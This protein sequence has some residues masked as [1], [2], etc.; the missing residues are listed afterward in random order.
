MSIFDNILNNNNNYIYRQ[1]GNP[2][3]LHDISY[4]V[5]KAGGPIN[6]PPDDFQK[7]ITFCTENGQRS[8]L[9]KNSE[10]N[11]IL[12]YFV[13]NFPISKKQFIL[14][15][16]FADYGYFSFVETWLEKNSD[17]KFSIGDKKLLNNIGY[18]DFKS[19]DIITQSL[20]ENYFNN[21]TFILQCFGDSTNLHNHDPNKISTNNF[22]VKQKTNPKKYIENSNVIINNICFKNY[23][24]ITN[25]SPMMIFR[26]ITLFE[27]F[28]FDFDSNYLIS[29]PNTEWTFEIAK[30]FKTKF[31]WCKYDFINY[32]NIKCE[33]SFDII[34]F[35]S[36]IDILNFKITQE[37]LPHL[38]ITKSGEYNSS[39]HYN[40]IK[41]LI[42]YFSLE[43]TDEI[44]KYAFIINNDSI[45]SIGIE[46]GLVQSSDVFKYVLKYICNHY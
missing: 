5:N 24:K 3:S 8:L 20:F 30:E 26:F 28:D 43:L 32:F 9:A 14:F 35:F 38:L 19:N 17:T 27:S 12:E 1:Y 31:K 15:L 10:N 44:I 39:I 6:V 23:C 21:I 41:K 29:L 13:K 11:I 46:N 40:N 18:I 4:A 37:D 33:N 45:I 34:K 7:L 36:L 22:L 16:K 2:I 25:N 42:N